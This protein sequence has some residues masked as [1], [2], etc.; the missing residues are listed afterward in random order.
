MW[1]HTHGDITE[2]TVHIGESHV[3]CL[4]SGQLREE[5]V[6]LEDEGHLSQML[7]SEWATIEADVSVLELLS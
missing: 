2:D 4:A 7:F 3:E 1:L 5:Y 6:V